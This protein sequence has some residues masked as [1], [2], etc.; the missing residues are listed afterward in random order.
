MATNEN[1]IPIPGR[2]HSV[3]SEGHVAGADEIVDDV[4][5]MTQDE[6]NAMMV[7]GAVKTSFSATP[8]AFLVGAQDNSV[9]LA[10]TINLNANIE[11]KKNNSKIAETSQPAKE[12]RPEADTISTASPASIAYK[13][14]FDAGQA[15]EIA[16]ITKNVYV[17]YPISYGSQVGSAAPVLTTLSEPRLTAKGTYQINIDSTERYIIFKVPKSYVTGI[18][19]VYLVS[20]GTANPVDGA[21]DSSLSDENYDVWKSAA[22]FSDATAGNR[23]FEINR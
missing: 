18:S 21:I 2:L 4:L 11:I 20:E 17:V 19:N 3:A 7:G 14:S 15:I 8:N 22:P 9:T 10:A 13:A 1:L 5:G 16:D 6:I 23:T 12:L